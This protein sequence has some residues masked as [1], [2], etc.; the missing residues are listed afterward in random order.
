VNNNTIFENNEV[1]NSFTQCNIAPEL[2]RE[3]P[4]FLP[5]ISE[6][7]VARHY[8]NLS[9]LNFGVDT[10]MYPLGSCT[11][12]YNY[13]VLERLASLS[14]FLSL[15]PFQDE[16]ECQGIMEILF[17]FEKYL[18]ELFGYSAFSFQPCAGAHGEHT[19]LLII[20]EYLLSKKDE[21]DLVLIPDSAHGTNPSSA[22][23]S[24][25]RVKKI[26]SDKWGNVDIDRLKDT[27]SKEKVAVLMLTNPSTLGL[28]ENNIMLISELIHEN[29]GLL[30]YDGANA[31]ALMGKIRPGDMGFDV[32]HLN[33]HKTFGTPHGGGGPGS[34][35][36]GVSKELVSFLPFPVVTKASIGYRWDKPSNSIGRMHGFFGN[37]NVVIRGYVY[38]LLKGKSGLTEASKKAV[39]NANY[40]KNELKDILELPFA[41]VCMHEFVLSAQK[42]KKETGVSA[43]DIAK[44]LIDKGFHPP[45]IYFPLIV[46]ECLMIEPTE[47]ETKESMDKF[48]Q[49]MK[50]IVR[51]AYLMPEKIKAKPTT[52]VVT[53]LDEARAVKEPKLTFFG[54]KES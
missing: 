12:K 25:F 1:F 42:L 10:G 53:R 39:E 9:T 36:V 54:S 24:G 32:C 21:R 2:K 52:K 38:F 49:A 7:E 26:P 8:T 47:D 35:P 43:L 28:F 11:M 40:L 14:S 34:G 16:K 23:V 45:T 29:G 31:N 48:V 44:A 13:K 50:E 4:C 6:S 33:L 3:K 17:D 30:Y 20:K 5:N 19:G 41:R 15:N 27:L 18:C 51:D 37:I 22:I 46:S